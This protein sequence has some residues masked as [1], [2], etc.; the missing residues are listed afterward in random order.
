MTREE[1][2]G[3]EDNTTASM[4]IV[5]DGVTTFAGK[6]VTPVFRVDSDTY[7][8]LGEWARDKPALKQAMI[9]S[10]PSA[11]V[12]KELDDAPESIEGAVDDL[13]EF[14]AENA[15]VRVEAE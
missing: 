2:Q 10:A 11:D 4:E 1:Q 8:I 7:T 12:L 9:S 15:V 13:L 6:F 14:L 3:D 5:E